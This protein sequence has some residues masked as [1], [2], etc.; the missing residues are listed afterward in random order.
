[1]KHF[2][3]HPCVKIFS[4]LIL[5]C[6]FRDLPARVQPINPHEGD[7]NVLTRIGIAVDALSLLSSACDILIGK[8]DI[9]SGGTF[10][11]TSSGIYCL[12]EN[13]S[14]TTDAAITVSSSDVTIDM[15][16]HAL[17]GAGASTTGIVLNDGIQNVIIKNGTIANM[18]GAVTG[19][20]GIRSRPGQSSTLQN[21]MIQDMNFNNNDFVA[22]NMGFA[23]LPAATYPVDGILIQ[24]CKANNGGIAGIVIFGL[25]GIVRGCEVAGNNPISSGGIGCAGPHPTVLANSFLIEDCIV[26]GTLSQGVG[27]SNTYN[28]VIRNCIL[29]GPAGGLAINSSFCSNLVISDCFAQADQLGIQL[30]GQVA[31]GTALFIERCVCQASAGIDIQNALF[32]N[33]LPV[34]FSS[35]KVVDCVVEAASQSGSQGRAAFRITQGGVTPISNIIFKRCCAIGD[36]TAGFL[37]TC[38]GAGS[39]SNIVFEDCVAQHSPSGVGDGFALV[40]LNSGSVISN[41]VFSNCVAQG[42]RPGSINLGGTF[43]TTYQGDGFGIGSATQNIGAIK[44][45]VFANCV[46]EANAHDGFSLVSTSSSQVMSSRASLNNRFGFFNGPGTKINAFLSNVGTSNVAD[47]AGLTE[48]VFARAGLGGVTNKYINIAS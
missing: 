17:Y 33:D 24:N 44:N 48:P 18:R 41:V 39:L 25:S 11:I 34:F 7:W 20:T 4:F 38:T 40:N 8:S 32:G 45:V 43:A 21:I 30:F 9:G 1:M 14:F 23:L 31:P 37:L 36:F 5:I 29:Q 16:G 12:K 22:I 3:N 28:A 6:S 10:I 19:G 35:T 42:C 2:W 13:V 27:I 26:S 46:S 47:Y 15:R